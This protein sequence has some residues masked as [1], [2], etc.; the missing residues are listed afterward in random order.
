MITAFFYLLVPRYRSAML[1]GVFALI[2]LAPLAWAKDEKVD[3]TGNRPPLAFNVDPKPVDRDAPQPTSYASVVRVT[4]P[5]VVFVYSSKQVRS[6]EL[7]PYLDDPILRRF[8]GVPGGPGGARGRMPD[9]TQRGLGSGV[10]VSADGYILTNNHVVDEADDVNVSIGESSTKYD[11]KVIG[12]DALTDLAVLKIEAKNLQPAILGDSEQLQVGDVV[13][14]IGNPFGLGLTVTRGIVSALGRGNLGIEQ[15]EDFIQTDAA[16]NMGNS[17]GALIDTRGRVIGINTAILSR[18]GGFAGV[19]FA[20]PINLV[21][22]VAEQMV[23]T[24]AVTRGFLGVAPQTLTPELAT[25][26]GSQQG[27]LVA[28]VT[29]GGAA[30]KAGLQAGDVLTRI[31]DVEVREPRQL[32]LTVSQ[33][34]PGSRVTLRYEREGKERTATATLERRP[35]EALAG[36]RTPG[37]PADSE[38]GVL[39]GVAVMDLTAQARD[40]FDIPARV[41]GALVSQVDPTSA[42]ARQG[43]REGDVIQELDRHAVKDAA[44]AIKWSEDIPGPKVTVRVWRQGRSQFLV[45]DESQK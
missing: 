32:L 40:Q 28:E 5:S 38:K 33:L 45:I 44:E 7:A 2:L 43:L 36:A 21:R 13:F 26:F 9:Q 15:I 4:S 17:G 18:T 1:I 25:Q 8:F 35:D 6:E 39:N 31:N 16:I 42:A 37:D 34:P 23:R 24:G 11:A 41:V 20:I 10:I 27:V 3:R 12:T 30:D 19:G 29:P 22:N 14:A